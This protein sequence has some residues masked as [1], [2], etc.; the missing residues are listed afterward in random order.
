[1]N[2]VSVCWASGL[3]EVSLRLTL[4]RLHGLPFHVCLPELRDLQEI[5]SRVWY[6]TA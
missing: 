1:M 4:E 2:T 3:S 5:D 6:S